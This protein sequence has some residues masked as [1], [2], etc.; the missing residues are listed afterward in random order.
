MKFFCIQCRADRE[1]ENVSEFRTKHNRRMAKGN[2]PVCGLEL[3]RSL[4]ATMGEAEKN[5]A[6]S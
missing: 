6:Q 2:C 1:I 3:F 4:D 5:N